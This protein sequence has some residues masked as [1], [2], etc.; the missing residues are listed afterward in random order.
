MVII[1]YY[2]KKKLQDFFE[3]KMAELP[4]E[5][6]SDTFLFSFL[7]AAAWLLAPLMGYQ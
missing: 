7:F 2:L 1:G 3:T 6:L 5:L 4:S